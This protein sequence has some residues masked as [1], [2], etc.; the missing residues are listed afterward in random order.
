MK[1]NAFYKWIHRMAVLS[2][3]P[4]L[5]M[6][7]DCAKLYGPPPIEVL[8]GPPSDFMVFGTVLDKENNQPISD[9][10]VQGE[11]GDTV[12]STNEDGTFE[13]G[14]VNCQDLVFS[15]DGYQSKDTTLCPAEERLVFMQK[16]SEE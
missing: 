16:Q 13:L 2:G 11:N 5:T 12:A 14:A 4:A 1:K 8:Y 3:I 9:V 15:K 10:I 6:M 7:C